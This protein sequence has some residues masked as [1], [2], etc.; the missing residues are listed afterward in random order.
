[1]TNF[2][3]QDLSLYDKIGISVSGGTD[4]T[5]LFYLL[6]KQIDK[7]IYP[8]HGIDIH[9]PN[10]KWHIKEIYDIIRKMCPQSNLHPIQ[11]FE[12]NMKPQPHNCFLCYNKEHVPNYYRQ[13][14]DKMYKENKTKGLDSAGF[15]KRL[16]H[17]DGY[18]NIAKKENIPIIIFGMTASPPLH[19]MEQLGMP[20]EKRRLKHRTQKSFIHEDSE[21]IYHSFSPLINK[22]KSY[23]ADIYKKHDLMKNVFPLTSSCIG[24]HNDTNGFTEPCKKCY[25]CYEK[26]WA[27]KTYD[28]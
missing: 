17:D 7:P 24:F 9:R 1:M 23:V 8:I 13:K 26:K 28:K 16:A 27:F 3:G 6:A 5:C 14:A 15:A 18:Y 20:Y 11:Y 19:I 4:S 21:K 12:Y 10:S 2:F 25:W 22:D